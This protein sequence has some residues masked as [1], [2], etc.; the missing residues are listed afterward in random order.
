ME[1]DAVLAALRARVGPDTLVTSVCTGSMI[2]AA[3]GL[4]KGRRATSHWV[5]RPSLAAFGATPVD[6]RV[7]EDGNLMTGAGVS[8]GLD[9][10]VAIVARLRGKPYAEALMLQAEYAPEPPLPGGTPA[11]TDPAI[12]EP[13]R[14]MFAPLV[15]KMEAIGRGG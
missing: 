5:T 3:A 8:A 14:D 6:A 13:M 12:A 7:V 11:S 15:A 2:L 9:L 1:D 10:G 4:L